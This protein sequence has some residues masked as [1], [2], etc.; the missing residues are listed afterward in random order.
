MVAGEG[1]RGEG[2]VLGARVER[3][4]SSIP[5]AV[6]S[7]SSQGTRRRHEATSREGWRVLVVPVLGEGPVKMETRD[8][9]ESSGQLGPVGEKRANRLALRSLP[10]ISTMRVCH[11]SRF[12][13][14][15]LFAVSLRIRL[16]LSWSTAEERERCLMDGGR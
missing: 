13:L 9:S 16:F 7:C 5:R 11:R 2:P 6:S 1:E 15:V 8:G 10:R 12:E 3:R 4:L 14:P